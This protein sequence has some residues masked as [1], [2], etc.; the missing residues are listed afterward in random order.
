MYVR[1]DVIRR[2]TDG[3]KGQ[4]VYRIASRYTTFFVHGVVSSLRMHFT[5]LWDLALDNA[6]YS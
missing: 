1:A 4:F 5:V 2:G 3:E 6:M